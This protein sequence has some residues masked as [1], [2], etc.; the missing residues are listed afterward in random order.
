MLLKQMLS[1]GFVDLSL[2]IGQ[3]LGACGE[4]VEQL[5]R[6]KPSTFSRLSLTLILIGLAAT[7]QRSYLHSEHVSLIIIAYFVCDCFAS[8]EDI[9]KYQNI[10]SNPI[11]I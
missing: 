2:Q 8:L 11:N 3:G 10:P 1:V 7:I 4:R 9:L 5:L 6:G